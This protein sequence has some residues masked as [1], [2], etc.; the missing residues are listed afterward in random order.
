[1]PIAESFATIISLAGAFSTGRDINQNT[2]LIEFQSW[3][4]ESGHKNLSEDIENSHAT[5]IYI[6]ALLNQ[7]LPLIIEA[8]NE[9]KDQSLNLPIN[10]QSLLN[11]K[12]D[13]LLQAIE[14]LERKI[15][16]A[17]KT[18]V[19]QQTSSGNRAPNVAHHGNGNISVNTGDSIQ[20]QI[21]HYGISI[22]DHKRTLEERE[23]EVR[24]ELSKSNAVVLH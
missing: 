14:D 23:R 2:S 12:S 22:D 19:N 9:L 21:N 4:V 16:S 18:Q 6:K 24:E 17:D 11:V 5:G 15:Q 3:L 1:M 13:V 8:I 7:Q 20:T 10:I